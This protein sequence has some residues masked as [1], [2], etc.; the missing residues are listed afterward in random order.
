MLYAPG[1]T[2]R[3]QNTSDGPVLDGCET[4]V[5]LTGWATSSRLSGWARQNAL[6]CTSRSWLSRGHSITRIA[7]GFLAPVVCTVTIWL[8][9][10]G[11]PAREASAH[12]RSV[13]FTTGT[14]FRNL[15][16]E[17]RT[18]IRWSLATTHS[19]VVLRSSTLPSTTTTG[20][21]SGVMMSPSAG[22]LRA[23]P[24]KGTGSG[25]MRSPAGLRCE[26]ASA[27]AGLCG[28]ATDTE[29]G[30]GR[31]SAGPASRAS[32]VFGVVARDDAAAGACRS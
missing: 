21:S 28:S 4:A 31:I 1:R 29:T 15:P 19:V 23:M 7:D 5:S 11:S 32:G 16:S 2:F 9:L 3:S 24:L 22:L 6:T 12:T 8:R 17:T 25:G 14:I 10:P 18:G 13:G 20:G 30:S 27:V 26:D